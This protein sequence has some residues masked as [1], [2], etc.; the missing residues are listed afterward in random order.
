MTWGAAFLFFLA[1]FNYFPP[2]DAPRHPLPSPPPGREP[3]LSTGRSPHSD[4]FMYVVLTWLNSPSERLMRRN[5]LVKEP[6]GC[7]HSCHH[8]LN[9]ELLSVH[10]EASYVEG[11]WPVC[12]CLTLS[13]SA[14]QHTTPSYDQI[15]LPLLNFTLPHSTLSARVD[16]RFS[17]GWR[18][19][20]GTTLNLRLH[21]SSM[22]LLCRRAQFMSRRKKWTR[23][24]NIQ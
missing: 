20:T 24:L 23:C 2:S 13:L 18:G 16:E 3:A 8:H 19:W 15:S 9:P 5:G 14:A 11:K 10:I 21:F 6:T 4:I 17:N 1:Y 22:L 7:I 12:V